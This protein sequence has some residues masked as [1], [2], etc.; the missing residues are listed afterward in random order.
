M[1]KVRGYYEVVLRN[2][3]RLQLSAVTRADEPLTIVFENSI[4]WETEKTQVLHF[5]QNTLV[6]SS[7]I[8][9]IKLCREEDLEEN[10]NDERN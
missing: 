2:G 3:L 9:M 4:I 5:E 1:T 7:E 8:A 10:D 6:R